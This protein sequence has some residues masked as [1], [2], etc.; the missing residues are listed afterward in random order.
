MVRHEQLKKEF[1]SFAKKVAKLEVLKRELYALDTR[2]FEN[3]VKSIR[4]K[5]KNVN[6]ILNTSAAP[7]EQQSAR[8][9]QTAIGQD[10]HTV[11]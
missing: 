10:K 3:N 8:E 9:K 6:A 2:G 11:S 4:A 7:K 5:L 1:E